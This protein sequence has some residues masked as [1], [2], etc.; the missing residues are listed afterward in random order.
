VWFAIREPETMAAERSNP[1]SLVD[2]LRA[3]ALVEPDRRAVTFLV[4][5]EADEAH[6]TYAELD[7]RARAV[8]ARLQAAGAAGSR[9]VLL[10]PP[11][12]DYVAAFF[13]CLYAGV[14]AVPAYPPLP[15]RSD[16]ALPTIVA[17]SQAKFAL[18]LEGIRSAAEAVLPV[19]QDDRLTWIT[20]D[21]L[22]S[23]GGDAWR[24]PGIAASDIAFLQYS[25]GS[26]GDPK[27]VV[28]KHANL[29]HHAA[30]LHDECRLSPRSCA[31]IWLPPYHDMGL[32]GGI[33]QPVYSG[34]PTVLMSPLAFLERPI[35]WLR[36]ISRFRGTATAGPNFA[37]DLCV[38]KT[39]PEERAGLDLRSL[40]I[41]I[42]GAEPIDAGTLERFSE[43]FAPHGFRRKAFM[44][45]YGLAEAT[46]RV[47][48]TS[49]DAVPAVEPVDPRALERGVAVPHADGQGLVGCGAWHSSQ[50]VEIVDP[51]LRTVCAEGEVGEIWVSGPAVASGY[52]NREDE[53]R[54]TF[55]ARI[56]GREEERFL[57]TGDLGFVRGGELFVTGRVKDVMIVNGR[58]I[59]PQ[60]VERT[61]ERSHRGVRPGCVAAFGLQVDDAELPAV[62]LEVDPRR[63]PDPGGVVRSIQRAVAEE[64]QV[65]LG[66]VTLIERGGLPKT[67]SG[68]VR[69]RETRKR[70]LSDGLD[71]VHQWRPRGRRDVGAPDGDAAGGAIEAGG[72]PVADVRALL[73][74]TDLEGRSRTI[75]SYLR[76]QVA[77][78]L[79]VD[80]GE[81]DVTEPPSAA[82]LD[83]VAALELKC[84]V[85][86]DLG[87]TLP[88]GDVLKA[89][90]LSE[91]A[92][93]LAALSIGAQTSNGGPDANG[94]GLATVLAELDRLPE[95][96]VDALLCAMLNQSG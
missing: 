62:A 95:E 78:A 6:L 25:S 1:R 85:E 20:T 79:E 60:D 9:A 15:N 81:I 80:P 49:I 2:V 67:S 70:F 38:R 39:T 89:A 69:R 93:V 51:H 96:Q 55:E 22:D 77:R 56:A 64:H 48:G 50:R 36:A 45:C 82:G 27:G 44:A 61:V 65:A 37:Y 54:Q 92:L 11:G 41:A 73:L 43:A 16:S 84:R 86:D 34:F 59:Y 18:S 94:A 21:G 7:R 53:T 35:R 66:A 4:D 57:R 52:W 76:D 5:G 74:R 87:V 47:T 88:V 13:G 10:Y 75:E 29:L 68:K 42:D 90:S 32:I 63:A 40:T 72:P 17:D 24:D 30:F 19:R 58:N 14:P 12:L 3:R 91:L 46:L 28:L 71:V 8:A 23:D 31:V 83:S 33:L 26:T